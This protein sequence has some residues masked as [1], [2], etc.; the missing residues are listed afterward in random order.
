V[1]VLKVYHYPNC[2]T[3]KKALKFLANNRYAVDK[4]DI[5][6]TPPT[7]EEIRQMVTL[8]GGNYRKLFNSAGHVYQEMN[9]KDKLKDMPF[10]EVV[11]L[12]ASNGR[13]VKRPFI[14]HGKIGLLGFDEKEWKAALL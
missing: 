13:L 4:R 2:S 5:F 8:H 14:L 1:T 3:C 11:N 7:K 12:L 9:L 6:K 10:D